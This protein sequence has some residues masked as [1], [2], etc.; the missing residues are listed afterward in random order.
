MTATHRDVREVDRDE[1]VMRA[2]LLEALNPGPMTIPELAAAIGHPTG[3]VVFWVM[4]LRKYGLV[5]EIPEADDEGFFRYQ[6][7]GRQGS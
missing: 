3:E 2:V 1:Q 6:L 7:A 4:G 5:R